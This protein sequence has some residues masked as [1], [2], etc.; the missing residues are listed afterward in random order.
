MDM[1]MFELNKNT[2]K[3]L[4]EQLYMGIK[5]A[6][7]SQQI[8]VGTQLLQKKLADFLNI[9]QT[10]IEVAY[11]QLVAEGFIVSKPRIGFL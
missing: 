5:T 3:P 9:S 10:T 6:I 4:Y 1:L 2:T 8:E 11:A 7:L